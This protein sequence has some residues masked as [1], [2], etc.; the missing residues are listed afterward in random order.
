MCGFFASAFGLGKRYS[1]AGV[2]SICRRDASF[3]ACVNGM[4]GLLTNMIGRLF[5]DLPR[6]TTE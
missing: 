5:V 1:L 3:A 6:R 4:S 2:S